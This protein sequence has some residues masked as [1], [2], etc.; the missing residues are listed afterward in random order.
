MVLFT[1]GLGADLE[2]DALQRMA[3]RPEY[4]YKAP[5]AE[6]L[7]EIYR[8]I[9]VAV[10]CPEG[11]FGG[12]APMAH[13]E[14]LTQRFNYRTAYTFTLSNQPS[15]TGRLVFHVEAAA[16]HLGIRLLNGGEDLA[17][18][19][20][21]QVRIASQEHQVVDRSGRPHHLVGGRRD[22]RP[23]SPRDVAR[24]PEAAAAVYREGR[25]LLRA[26][27]TVDQPCPGRGP[28]IPSR[29]PPSP[30]RG[31]PAR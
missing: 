5:D 30:S 8:R 24:I 9:A 7:T 6:S 31:P 18:A 3:S 23:P 19:V 29:P 2:E 26:P 1:I 21:G 25:M 11:R 16:A 15:P 27:E 12:G 20:Q 17:V 14:R 13:E 10:P 22:K 28:A 4:F